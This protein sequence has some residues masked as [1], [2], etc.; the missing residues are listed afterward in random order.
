[1]PV[2]DERN[3]LIGVI[4]RADVL[5][6]YGR[7]ESDIAGEVIETAGEYGLDPDDMTVTVATGV[8]TLEGSIH[9]E[10]AALM[11]AARTRHMERIVAVR[12]RLIREEQTQP[13]VLRSQVARST[14]LVRP[15]GVA[16]NR[17]A[18]PG[19]ATRTG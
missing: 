9:Q 2:V 4:S 15:V 16:R 11:L 5:S 8:V 1:M 10:E 12:D 13:G 17:K 7:P 6:V 19:H 14:R 3:H 18:L